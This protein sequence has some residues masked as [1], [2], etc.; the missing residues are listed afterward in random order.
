MESS[1][2][3]IPVTTTAETIGAMIRRQYLTVR[4]S[5]PSNRPQASTVPVTAPYP[6]FAAIA[7][8]GTMKVKLSPI[9]IGRPEPSFR[10]GV[11]WKN[12]AIPAAIMA[13]CARA[14][15]SA[16]D[17]AGEAAAPTTLI[18]IILA[19]N[20]AR[21]CC[22]EKGS[23]RPSPG[24][25]SSVDRYRAGFSCLNLFFIAYSSP[26]FL[27]GSGAFPRLPTSTKTAYRKLQIV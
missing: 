23:S 15:I 1:D 5:R 26:P 9:M 19:T 8:N 10:T 21:I 12:V 4:P 3:P 24:L 11:A 18:G 17:S 14:R 13:L 7:V 20:I 25:P 2:R 22:S 27:L 16:R 6:Y